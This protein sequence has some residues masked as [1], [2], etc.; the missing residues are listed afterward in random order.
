MMIH[1]D[2]DLLPNIKYMFSVI[3][4]LAD[5]GTFCCLTHVAITKINPHKNDYQKTGKKR[6]KK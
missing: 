4:A 2:L 6:R 5:P 1:D 3:Q